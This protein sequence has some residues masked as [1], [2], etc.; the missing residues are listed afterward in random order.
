MVEMAIPVPVANGLLLAH[1]K[2]RLNR[3]CEE[4]P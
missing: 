4:M 2:E 3:I 1:H